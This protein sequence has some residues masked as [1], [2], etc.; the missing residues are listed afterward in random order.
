VLQSRGRS[1]VTITPGARSVRRASFRTS[2]AWVPTEAERTR[3]S[4]AAHGSSCGDGPLHCASSTRQDCGMAGRSCDERFSGA[5]QAALIEV[6]AELHTHHELSQLFR[7]LDVEEESG[8]R[9]TKLRRVQ[10]MVDALLRRAPMHGSDVLELCRV[11]LEERFNERVVQA[12]PQLRGAMRRLLDGLKVDGYE[13]VD[14]QLV[15]TNPDAVPVAED[16]TA[17]VVELKARGWTVALTHY[18]QAVDNSTDSEFES[19]NAQLRSFLEELLTRAVVACN[20]QP[21]ADPKGN[22]DKLTNSSILV[23]DEAEFLKGLVRLS[24]TNGSHPGISTSDESRFRL[25]V[26]VASAR[27]VLA[28]LGR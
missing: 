6:V 22:I 3:S 7:R 13:L 14:R 25:H 27:W 26:T 11:V 15:K 5:T 20:G 4:C 23:K 24:N 9:Q 18:R 16:M 17:L 19:S 2:R 10:E 1:K 28:L 21:S 8:R 12:M